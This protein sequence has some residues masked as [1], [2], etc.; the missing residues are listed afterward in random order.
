M[1]GCVCVLGKT[2]LWQPGR[3]LGEVETAQISKG[4]NYTPFHLGLLE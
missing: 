4:R 3:S 1:E 2:A